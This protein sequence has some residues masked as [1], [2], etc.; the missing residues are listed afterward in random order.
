MAVLVGA[1]LSW[2][3]VDG[4]TGT[5]VGA[6]LT[7]PVGILGVVSSVLHLRGTLPPLGP[8]MRRTSPVAGVLAGAEH[9]RL[10]VHGL[11]DV[12]ERGPV[13]LR[14]E[15]AERDARRAEE[16]LPE[17]GVLPEEP[18]LIVGEPVHGLT[19]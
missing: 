12:L 5:L 15:I 11:G 19:R 3:V 7:M 17:V 18:H 8:R 9:L 13:D 1:A 14:V 16:Q 10:E 4:E 2:R 6:A